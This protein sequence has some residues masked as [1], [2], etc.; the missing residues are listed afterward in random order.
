[1]WTTTSH[2]RSEKHA[3]LLPCYFSR[4]REEV[5]FQSFVNPRFA[6][7]D[8]TIVEQGE[9]YKRAR[10]DIRLCARVFR[11]DIEGEQISHFLSL[12]FFRC[13]CIFE[14][15]RLRISSNT[16]VFLP[17]TRSTPN[18]KCHTQGPTDLQPQ[19]Y[20]SKGSNTFN[21]IFLFH[22]SHTQSK[23]DPTRKHG[24]FAGARFC[25]F[26]VFAYFFSS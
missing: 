8:Q 20:L 25:F 18:P 21:F 16:L 3:L 22:Q 26:R 23:G 12:S 9:P 19:E 10:R 1:M 15:E 11:V 5:A 24:E 17:L 2:Y 14:Q 6:T 13:E 4:P 7:G